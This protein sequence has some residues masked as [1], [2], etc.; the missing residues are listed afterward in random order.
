MKNRLTFG[1]NFHMLRRIQPKLGH[2]CNMGTLIC[3]WGQRSHI[4]VKG[5]LKSSCKVGLKCKIHLIWK[6][7]VWNQTWFIDVGTFPCSRRQRSQMKVK[8]HVKLN[9]KIAWK[10]K[11]WLICIL[12]DQLEPYDPNAAIY[13]NIEEHFPIH[14][15]TTPSPP[16]RL[17]LSKLLVYISLQDHWPT[18]STTSSGTF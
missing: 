14:A 1:S 5:H 4:K 3:W 9:C 12:E 10:C 13:Q 18:I 15:R 6:V 8:G 17:S 7:E 11:I 2:R 16:P